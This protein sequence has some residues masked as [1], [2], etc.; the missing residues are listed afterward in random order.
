MI[1][2]IQRCYDLM[3]YNGAMLRKPTFTPLGVE[4]STPGEKGG[5]EYTPEYLIECLKRL[6]GDLGYVPTVNDV[7]NLSERIPDVST[8]ERHFGSY[9]EALRAAGLESRHGASN[10]TILGQLAT[11]YALLGGRFPTKEELNADRET[12]AATTYVNRFGSLGDTRL[13]LEEYLESR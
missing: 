1:F 9:K 6:A 2:S 11:L 10:A 12:P 8:F 3:R 7:R 5:F 4:I 13:A